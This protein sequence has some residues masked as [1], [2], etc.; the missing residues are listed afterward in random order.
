[1]TSKKNAYFKSLL[2]K[3]INF[4]GRTGYT[5]CEAQGK[6]KCGALFKKLGKSTIKGTKM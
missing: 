1:V 6:W 5:I 4:V 2:W 3:K